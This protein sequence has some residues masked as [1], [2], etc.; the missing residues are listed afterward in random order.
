MKYQLLFIEID[1]SKKKRIYLSISSS[2]SITHIQE[3]SFTRKYVDELV[4]NNT[5]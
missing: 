1:Q 2:R 5:L 4:K 3:I